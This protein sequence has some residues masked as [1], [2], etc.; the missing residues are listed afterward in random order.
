MVL[1]TLA[2][3]LLVTAGLAC[4]GSSSGTTSDAGSKD[5]PTGDN[6]T[7]PTAAAACMARATAQCTEFA[8]CE[9]FLINYRYG[10]MDAC[11]SGYATNCVNSLAAP[12]TGATPSTVQAC[13]AA[14]SMWSC[15][16]FV[17][18]TNPP[19]AC[20][21]K[22]GSL[23]NG[24]ACG[25]PA[26]CSSGYCA[27]TPNALCGTCAPQPTEGQSCAQLS[28]CG[29]GLVCYAKSQTC[30]AYG[31]S[32]AACDEDTPCGYELSCVGADEK[33]GIQGKC[34]ADGTTVGATCDPKQKTGP[35]C[36]FVL[37]LACN[38]ETMK[39]AMTTAGT[40]CGLASDLETYCSAGGTCI[41]DGGTCTA[42]AATGGTCDIGG[43]ACVDPEKCIGAAEGGTSGTCQASNASSCK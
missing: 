6:T 39:C 27:I 14:Y 5:S 29:T 41:A 9:P 17:S 19:S 35:G 34:T 1:R 11:V 20:A 3:T 40:T 15:P 28:T 38:T 32:G 37:G 10:T 30:V 18:N 13:A 31:A 21:Q 43:P 12:S 36:A 26:Q 24:A 7:G 8:K 22:T 33:T 25:F 42:A 2:V 16:D 23:A 4:G